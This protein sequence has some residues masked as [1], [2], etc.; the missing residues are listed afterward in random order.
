[1]GPNLREAIPRQYGT[2][3]PINGS[4]SLTRRPERISKWEI[5]GSPNRIRTED[6]LVNSQGFETL[7]LV[8]AGEYLPILR[9]C[10]SPS[11]KALA[12][13]TTKSVHVTVVDQRGEEDNYGHCGFD[14]D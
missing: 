2:F 6:L 13:G 9:S 4:A 1:M 3:L 12:C 7:C 8:D 11:Q 10:P 5:F 14:G